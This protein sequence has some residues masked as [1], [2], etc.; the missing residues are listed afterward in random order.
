[1]PLLADVPPWQM[2]IFSTVTN[3]K[4]LPGTS[5]LQFLFR[6]MHCRRKSNS[7]GKCEATKNAIT[8]YRKFRH[9]A[10]FDIRSRN[11]QIAILERHS[12][13]MTWFQSRKLYFKKPV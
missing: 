10:N 11:K 13:M 1:M 2:I 7:S 8:P 9:L 12:V 3:E 5:G 4:Q 6:G